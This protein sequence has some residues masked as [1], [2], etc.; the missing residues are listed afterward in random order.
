MSTEINTE[1]LYDS[2]SRN[3]YIRIENVDAQRKTIT[4]TVCLYALDKTL[5]VDS[6]VFTCDY[7]IEN[8]SPLRQAYEHLKNVL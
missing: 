7:D 4:F 1:T 3:G 6:Q 5:G 2:V 8:D